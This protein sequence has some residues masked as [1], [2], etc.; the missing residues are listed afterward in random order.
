MPSRFRRDRAKLWINCVDSRRG[1]KAM[2]RRVFIALG[3]A[4]ALAVP[5]AGSQIFDTPRA[6]LEY[7]YA[8]Y[9][10]G[11]FEDDSDVLYTRALKD[12]FAAAE[13][14]T[15]EDE[16]GPVDFDVFVNAQDFEL[17]ELAIGEPTPE[18][19]GVTVP[20]TFKNFGDP[21]SLRFHLVQEGPGW[22]IDDIEC[23]TPGS[24]WRLTSLL[25]PPPTGGGAGTGN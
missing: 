7:A 4:L 17:S 3:L 19:Q 18:G 22:K 8:P 20:V 5:A 6:L 2:L 23:L 25:A 12:L 16:V 9:A 15:G 1:E 10:T 13:A 21:Q 14:N 11:N 24:E